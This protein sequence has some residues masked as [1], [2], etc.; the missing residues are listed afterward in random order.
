MQ[1][2]D[3]RFNLCLC[4][5]FVDYY[6]RVEFIILEAITESFNWKEIIKLNKK[7]YLVIHITYMLLRFPFLFLYYY[8]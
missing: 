7:H 2:R 4:P 5:Q 8:P 6:P 1:T 3:P